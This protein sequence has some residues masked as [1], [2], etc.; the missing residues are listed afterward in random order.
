MTLPVADTRQALRVIVVDDERPAL[1]RLRSMLE[2]LAGVE[3]VG[4]AEDG[5]GAVHL[6]ATLRPDL[7][8]LDVEMPGLD[9]VATARA[10]RS[11]GGSPLV[12]FATAYESFALAAFDVEAV[13]YLLKPYEP[14][15]L[16]EAVDRARARLA[17]RRGDSASSHARA[18][19][20]IRFGDARVDVGSRRAE[21]AGVSVTLRRRELELLLALASA[22]GA[23]VSR[24]DLLARVW[25][26][27]REVVSRT[28]DTH[29][30]S[31]RQKFERDPAEPCFLLTERGFGYR[32]LCDHMA[33]QRASR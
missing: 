13:D 16:Q 4:A 23:P 25:G 7:V 1:R 31:L 28:L 33:P 14:R 26:Y 30:L 29:I 6:V 15:R 12:V 9:G 2:R 32:L 27:D 11:N 20:V 10:I 5:H 21:Y 18:P 8:F 22:N 24:A 3:V 19:S 17:S